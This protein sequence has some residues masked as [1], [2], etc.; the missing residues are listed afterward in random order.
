ML[1]VQVFLRLG[2][3][4]LVFVPVQVDL[5]SDTRDW[6]SFSH[7]AVT[8]RTFTW[9]SD[10]H[11]LSGHVKAR[12]SLLLYKCLTD[13]SLLKV[14]WSSLFCNWISKTTM[15]NLFYLIF[16]ICYL[17]AALNITH[18][19]FCCFCSNTKDVACRDSLDLLCLTAFCLL[20]S[21]IVSA[22]KRCI[23]V[24]QISQLPN[25]HISSLLTCG[26]FD[27]ATG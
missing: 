19:A 2:A 4:L 10:V 27:W 1:S 21:V 11:S 23:T 14:L 13:F 24:F 3:L 16:F 6:A 18:T 15:Q 25:R 9:R 8:K 26:G 7:W 20:S 17:R 12:T 22:L 5:S